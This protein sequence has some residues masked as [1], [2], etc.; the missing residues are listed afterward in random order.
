MANMINFM[1]H[2]F[3]I[4]LRNSHGLEDTEQMLLLREMCLLD[5]GLKSQNYQ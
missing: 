2:I 4:I 1:L 3:I 5:I